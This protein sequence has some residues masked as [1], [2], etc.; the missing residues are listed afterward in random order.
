MM[1]LTLSEQSDLAAC[2]EVIERGIAS[3]VETG[4]AL[5]RVRDARLYRATHATFEAY[6]QDRWSMTRQHANRTIAAA[7]VISGLEPISSTPANEAQARELAPLRGQPEKLRE[8]W[9]DAQTRGNGKPTAELVRE[10]VQEVQEKNDAALE[11][12][13]ERVKRGEVPPPPPQPPISDSP[14]QVVLGALER[15][16]TDLLTCGEPAAVVALIN[17]PPHPIGDADRFIQAAH[18]AYSWVGAFINAWETRMAAEAIAE[19]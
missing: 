3:F 16:L 1:E 9:D 11:R 18:E 5:M 15:L 6:C 2:E 10:V 13:R 8:A 7:E 17:D 4:E 14:Y 19:S 12:W